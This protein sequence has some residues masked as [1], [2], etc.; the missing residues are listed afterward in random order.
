MNR[1]KKF[2]LLVEDE[3]EIAD[4][5]SD[6]FLEQGFQVIKTDNLKDAIF[7]ANNQKFDLVVL[8][9]KLKSGTGDDFV[10]HV[11]TNTKHINYKSPIVVTSAWL[12]K[13]LIHT[14]GT[15]IDYAFVKPFDIDSVISKCV[16]IMKKNEIEA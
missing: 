8:D 9:I 10:R 7:K 11:K 5:I 6:E 16:E 3:E 15:G 14:V 12:T 1:F 4:F 2:I 13:D